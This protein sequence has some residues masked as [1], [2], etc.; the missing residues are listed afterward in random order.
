MAYSLLIPSFAAPWEIFLSKIHFSL[1][2]SME[3]SKSMKNKNRLNFYSF[4]EYLRMELF[5]HRLQVV[6]TN[7]CIQ[8]IV[9]CVIKLHSSK[10]PLYMYNEQV[11]SIIDSELRACRLCILR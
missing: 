10:E 2:I 8:I 5:E 11:T 1:I 9:H 6:L 4:Y 7:L 3:G